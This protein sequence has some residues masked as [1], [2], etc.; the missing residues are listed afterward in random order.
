MKNIIQ[1][2]LTA[3]RTVGYVAN[4][5]LATQIALLLASN[6]GS[7][8]AMLLDGPPG[9][10]KT[11]LAKCVARMMGVDYIYTQAHPGS[12]PED[13]LYDANIVQIL[14]GAAGDRQAVK[15]AEDV[16]ELGFLPIIFR[17]SQHGPVVAF[18]DELDKAN[19]KTDSLFLSA[20]QE[21]EV[22]VRGIGKI[23]A[24]LSN[25]VLFFTKNDERQISEP[26]MRRC[27]R[28]YLGFPSA[29]LEMAILTGKV[30]GGKIE[31]ALQI[32][33]E[34]VGAIPEAV[35][36]VL[37]TVANQLRAKQEDLIK[38]PATQE[39]EMAGHDVVRLARWGVLGMAGEVAFG[40]LAGFQEDRQILG[41]IMSTQKLGELLTT[42][43]KSSAMEISQKDIAKAD[44]EFVKFGQ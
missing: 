39:L 6:G 15:S 27:R 20:L 32:P 17:A 16:V 2:T 34:P 25:L 22:I 23:R 14:R 44:G 9:A 19:P 37:I 35:A 4:D 31:N 38:A 7:V 1:E 12:V 21:G 36:K 43:I 13:F 24:N 11:H 30:K 42:A 18:V 41:Q 29:D 26:L 40:W 33:V 3:L 8:K 5:K 10:G 28:E